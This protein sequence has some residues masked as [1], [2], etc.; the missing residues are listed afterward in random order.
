MK[1]L[2]ATLL[3]LL[4]SAA[5]AEELLVSAPSS[6][7]FFA[8]SMSTVDDNPVALGSFKGKPLIVNFWARWCGPCRKEIPDLAEMH[9]KHK[10]KGLLIVG[11]AVEDAL[12]RDSVREFAKAYEMNYTLLIGGVEK[13]VELMKASGNP[14]S[15]LPFTLAI[16][17]SGRITAMKLGAMS[18]AEMEAAIKQIL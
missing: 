10:A 11:I 18:K 12:H 9:E 2:L 14:K 5:S 1:L 6:A 17:K 8:L 13:S 3:V 16:D 7:P 4:C 15:G